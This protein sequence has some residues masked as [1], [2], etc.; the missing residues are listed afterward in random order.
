[1]FIISHLYNQN[2]IQCDH[3]VIKKMVPN[4]SGPMEKFAYLVIDVK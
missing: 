2:I 1:M 4:F 3:L